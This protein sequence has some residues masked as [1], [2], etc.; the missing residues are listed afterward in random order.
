MQL[1][2]KKAIVTGAGQGIGKAIALELARRGSDIAV[3]DLNLIECDPTEI[4]NMNVLMTFVD[5]EI[6]FDGRKTKDRSERP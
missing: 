6:V 2:G 4:L 5:G 1:E 3:C